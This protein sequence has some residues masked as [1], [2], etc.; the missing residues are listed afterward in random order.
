KARLASD[1][2]RGGI[3]RGVGG[4]WRLCAAE[5][6][7][8]LDGAGAVGDVYALGGGGESLP[9]AQER[10][11]SAA[12]VASLQRPCPSPCGRG[13]VGLCVVEDAGPSGQASGFDDV[14]PQ[15]GGSAVR[16]AYSQTATDDAR[17]HLA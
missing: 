16:P 12:G 1:V 13:C 5:Q 2:A 3:P 14:D 4:R 11:A 8:W 6:S 10:T 15:T 7:Q 17:S 9:R